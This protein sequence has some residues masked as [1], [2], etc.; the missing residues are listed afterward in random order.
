MTDRY[1]TA[2]LGA[3]SDAFAD[4]ASIH[5]S[6]A[7][8]ADHEVLRRSLDARAEK[9]ESLCRSAQ[10]E[11]G[12]PGSALKH[13]DRLKLAVDSWFGD[14]DAAADTAS[15]EAMGNVLR[16]LD[17]YLGGAE[18]SPELAVLLTRMRS[19]ILAEPVVAED[20]IRLTDLPN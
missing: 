20:D 10:S 9:L 4:A 1:D 15:R 11:E 5:R 13:L 2:A 19:K 3:L 8:I 6:A 16:L 12:E 7:R 18:I 17:Q 14:D